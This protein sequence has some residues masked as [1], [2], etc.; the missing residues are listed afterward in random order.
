MLQDAVE[1]TYVSEPLVAYAVELICA[2]RSNPL[3]LRGASPRATLA[4][5]ALS[6]SIAQLR[7][8]DY[9]VPEDVREVFPHA[10][11]H[12]LLLSTAAQAQNK[13]AADILRDILAAVPQ[14][15]LR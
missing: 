2:T 11:A 14:P 13:S 4:V 5:I 15:R 9:V 1:N 6:K 12:R 8:R 7:G 3:I 10:I